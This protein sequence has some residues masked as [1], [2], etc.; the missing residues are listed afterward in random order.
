MEHFN[1]PFFGRYEHTVRDD[2][3][4]IRAAGLDSDRFRAIDRLFRKLSYHAL[5]RHSQPLELQL[6]VLTLVYG[7]LTAKNMAGHASQYAWP[8]NI[9]TIWFD[10]HVIDNPD[11]VKK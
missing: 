10:P 5:P 8:L 7:I 3:K 1:S 2:I 11:I 6:D 4:I 9:D